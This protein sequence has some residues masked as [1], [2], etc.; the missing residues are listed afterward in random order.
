MA[1]NSIVD[2]AWPKR[3]KLVA[4]LLAIFLGDF[5]LQHFYLGHIK[6]GIV[7]LCFCWCFIPGLLGLIEGISWLMASDE[8]FQLKQEVRLY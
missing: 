8:K 3:N 1:K 7:R 4:A 5:G 2:P 6:K